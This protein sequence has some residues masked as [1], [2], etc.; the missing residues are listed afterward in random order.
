MK[1]LILAPQS[2]HTK[3]WVYPLLSDEKLE[4]LVMSFDSGN[5]NALKNIPVITIKSELG[6]LKYFFAVKNIK[7]TLYEFKPDIVHAHFVSSYGYMASKL[8]FHPLVLSAW[9]SDIT[10]AKENFI[11]KNFLKDVI[12]SSDYINFAGKW[13]EKIAVEDIGMKDDKKRDVF[14]YG[15][16]INLIKKFRKN[17][18]ER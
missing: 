13:L 9:G 15:V 8:N 1:V 18:N 6:K 7:K 17:I 10:L 2:V 12:N 11:R 3:K 5:E 4:I 16:D 14:Q